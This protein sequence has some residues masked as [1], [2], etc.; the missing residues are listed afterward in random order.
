MQSTE[1]RDQG[2]GSV[3]DEHGELA[4]EEP[5]VGCGA[6][7]AFQP[8]PGTRVVHGGGSTGGAAGTDQEVCSCAEHELRTLIL[9]GNSDSL[10]LVF[11][12]KPIIAD[13]SLTVPA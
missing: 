2:Y 9:K 4:P 10:I 12:V 6:S 8:H 3:D 11:I 7:R 5:G 1:L 13:E